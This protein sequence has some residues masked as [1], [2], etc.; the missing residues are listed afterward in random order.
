[1]K[2]AVTKSGIT[3]MVV[4]NDPYEFF[5][6]FIKKLPE[7]PLEDVQKYVAL[8]VS[9]DL[10][11]AAGGKV[12]LDPATG[13]I[14]KTNPSE[15]MITPEW[16]GKYAK[17]MDFVYEC[18]NTTVY[19]ELRHPGVVYKN[20]DRRDLRAHTLRLANRVQLVDVAS[21][22]QNYSKLEPGAELE[23]QWHDMAKDVK[24][25]KIDKTNLLWW[26]F[27]DKDPTKTLYYEAMFCDLIIKALRLNNKKLNPQRLLISLGEGK[28]TTIIYTIEP[29]ITSKGIGI[30]SKIYLPFQTENKPDI[31]AIQDF[32]INQ[33]KSVKI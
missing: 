14:D 8:P 16:K 21:I 31:N 18:M 7:L 26:S 17:S 32:L 28:F 22:L 27:V 1:M 23:A 6:I 11:V 2:K 3:V 5:D 12:G 19:T 13:S 4:D 15:N 30:V 29:S 25:A 9:M 10:F 20:L 33:M 24:A